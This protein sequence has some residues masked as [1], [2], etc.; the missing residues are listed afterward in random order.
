M[1]EILA[2]SRLHNFSKIGHE[3]RMFDFVTKIEKSE[4]YSVGS[5]IPTKGEWPTTAVLKPKIL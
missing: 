2:S 1:S 5:K 4:T 3:T